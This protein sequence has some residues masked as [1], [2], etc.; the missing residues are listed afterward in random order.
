MFQGRVSRSRPRNSLQSD[1]IE[2][3]NLSKLAASH[4]PR[5]FIP[6]MPLSE[7]SFPRAEESKIV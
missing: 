4:P 1:S 5:V 7:P 2:R 3:L 6:I